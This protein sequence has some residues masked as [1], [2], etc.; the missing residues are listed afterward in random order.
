MMNDGLSIPIPDIMDIEPGSLASFYT[1]LKARGMTKVGILFDEFADEHYRSRLLA[2]APDGVDVEAVKYRNEQTI[3]DLISRA[4]EIDR[5]DAICAMGGGAVIDAG[6]YIAFSRRTPFISIPISP[7]NDG[8][9]SSN[10]SLYVD[11]KKTTVPARVPYGIVADPAIIETAPRPLVLAGVGDL[12]SNITALYDWEYEAEIGAATVHAFASMLSKKA[13]NSFIRTP[14]DDLYS[15][16]FLKELISSLAMG[17][18]STVISGNSSPIS[19]A[20][21]MISHALDRTANKPQMHGVQVGIAS[22]L[23]ALVH[24]HRAER[25]VKVFERT[26]FFDYVQTLPLNRDEWLYA[27][28]IAPEMKPK[29]HTYLHEER[30]RNRAKELLHT[31]PVLNRIF[32]ESSAL[33]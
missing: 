29:R 19:G 5:Y 6:K 1:K 16:V 24:E 7:S 21:H 13:V 28:E 18:V 26:G 23:M 11:G 20:E 15:E 14:M 31:D 25:M 12:M 4:F 32:A 30:H 10:C 27:I 17:G 8:F 2:A 22:Y 9:A 33:E 3:H